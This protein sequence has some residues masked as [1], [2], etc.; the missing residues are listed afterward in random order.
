MNILSHIYAIKE[1]D[2]N[3]QVNDDYPFSN[4][5]IAHMLRVARSAVLEN[6]LSKYH[7]VSHHNYESVKMELI[8]GGPTGCSDLT[9]HKI[10]KEKVPSIIRSRRGDAINV[11]DLDGNSIARTTMMRYKTWAKADNKPKWY[12]VGG[13]IVIVNNNLLDW[14]LVHGLF[15]DA[16][17]SCDVVT[18]QCNDDFPIDADLVD[19]IYK[20]TLDY[21]SKARNNGQDTAN[22][23]N[24]ERLR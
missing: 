23:A 3:G 24:S 21:L 5:F 14:I 8:N 19:P 9:C 11:T 10:T 18:G 17:T 4:D 6:K 1:L 2:T 20:I 13:K 15:E 12:I 16:P 7:P 22:D